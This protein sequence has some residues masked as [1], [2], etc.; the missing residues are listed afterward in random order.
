MMT[1]CKERRSVYTG[2]DCCINDGLSKMSCLF[3]ER[4]WMDGWEN[5]CEP[6]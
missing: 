2:I 5:N 6:I 1:S 3:D 4:R